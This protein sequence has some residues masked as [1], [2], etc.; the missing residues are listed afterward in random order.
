MA[1]TFAAEEIH[2][3]DANIL[4]KDFCTSLFE[5]K[6]LDNKLYGI[7]FYVKIEITCQGT[8]SAGLNDYLVKK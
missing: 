4:G 7:Y 6:L 3:C 8:T 2:R 5:I 1:L